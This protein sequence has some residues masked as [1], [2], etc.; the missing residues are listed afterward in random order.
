MLDRHPG[1]L[2]NLVSHIPIWALGSGQMAQFTQ[3]GMLVRLFT[4]LTLWVSEKHLTPV[5]RYPMPLL[6]G[7]HSVRSQQLTHTP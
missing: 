5:D 6:L 3:V 7:L 2:D 1:L 4:Q